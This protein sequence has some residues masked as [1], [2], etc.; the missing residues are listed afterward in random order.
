[1][2]RSTIFLWENPLFLWA[3]FNSYVKL[4]KGTKKW[5]FLLETSHCRQL[6]REFA[7]C[8]HVEYMDMDIFAPIYTYLSISIYPSIHPS[9]HLSIY[10]CM[11]NNKLLGRFNQFFFAAMHIQAMARDGF[12]DLLAFGKI[13]AIHGGPLASEIRPVI[14]SDRSKVWSSTLW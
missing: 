14:G 2:E 1:M 12:L 9:I 4:P 10:S 11:F 5:F 8:L 6:L 13:W 7:F 3:I